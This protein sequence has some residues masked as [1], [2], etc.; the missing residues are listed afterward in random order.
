MGILGG[1]TPAIGAAR[2]TIVQAVR[3]NR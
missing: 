1:F 3:G 2:L